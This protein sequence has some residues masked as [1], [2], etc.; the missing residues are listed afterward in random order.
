MS[1]STETT[2]SG[3][4]E[5]LRRLATLQGGDAAFFVLAVH[6]F[7]EGA[8]RE[9]VV[10]DDPADDRFASFVDA[11]R[12]KLLGEAKGFIPGLDVLGLLKLQHQ[13]TN[14]VRHRFASATKEEARAAAQHL[15]R[16]CPL[17]G[18]PEGEGLR[19]VLGLLDAWE[20]RRSKGDLARELS[21]LEA[22][23]KFEKQGAK[24]MAARVAALESFQAEAARLKEELRRR[25]RELSEL[26]AVKAAQSGK[27][28]ALREEAKRL[29]A[30]LKAAQGKAAEFEDARAYLELLSRLTVLTRS[31]ADFERTIVRPTPEQREVLSQIR[32]D[33]DFLVKGSAGTGKTL[34]LLMAVE[35]AKG[36]GGQGELG[37][38]GLEGSAALLT[39]TNTLVKYDSYVSSI[40]SPEGGADL[41]QTVD[42]FL[43]DRLRALEPGAEID[44]DAAKALA[45]R[46]AP[47]GVAPRDL[48]AEAEDFLWANDVD[49]GR[50]VDDMIVRQGMKGRLSRSERERCWEA[51]EAMGAEMEK[52]GRYSKGRSRRRI[53][54]ALAAEPEDPR[55]KVVDY[56]FVD[57]AQDLTMADLKALK[58]CARKAVIL[59]GDADQGIYLPGFGFKAAGVA[60]AGRTRVLRTNFRNTLPV[61]ELAERYRAASPGLDA[62]SRP[63]AY[64]DGPA[65]ELFVGADRAAL[66]DL[67]AGR[68]DLL[69]RRLGYSPES[70]AVLVPLGDDVA[71]V[72][73]RLEEAGYASSDI[74]DRSFEFAGEGGVRVSTLHSSK[75]LD[76]PVVLLFLYRAPYFGAAFDEAS[77]ELMTRNLVYVAMT[78][79]MDQ[80]AVFALESPSSAAI[81]DLAASFASV[82]GADRPPPG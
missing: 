34:V 54:R 65:P 50:Y 75:G 74:R 23:L 62:E 63:E 48:A 31:R 37:L 77:T 15:R 14:D 69:V 51:C 42:A 80:L 78:R 20:D 21:N 82:G 46:F 58:G 11:F 7:V 36:R 52:T 56:V 64:R 25:E 66:L 12:R 4:E 60:I 9:L 35:K 13:L 79:A 18:I 2:L 81:K 24:E 71:L 16:F 33:G 38:P 19:A 39:Y 29:A 76:F 55:L 72:R 17:A 70:I 73:G 32:L 67:L 10:L 59:A 53:L 1:A 61:H 28:D 43:R 5:C 26:A 41:V 44:Y 8:L 57:E 22:R 6:S 3:Y 45:E 68:V 40:L 30:E 27:A 47:E 49:R